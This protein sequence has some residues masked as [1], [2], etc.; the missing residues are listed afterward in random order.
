MP[1]TQRIYGERPDLVLCDS[2]DAA[3]Q[4][5]DILVVITEWKQ[6]RSPDFAKLASALADAVVFDGRNLYAPD[7]VS[8]THLDVYKRQPI[9]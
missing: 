8:Y 4:A 7:A 6:F 3:L 2:A 1:E 9:R 5:A